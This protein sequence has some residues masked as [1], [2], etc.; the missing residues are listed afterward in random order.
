MTAVRF[1]PLAPE[2]AM[3]LL[4]SGEPVEHFGELRVGLAL[5]QRRIDRRAVD[6]A[7]EIGAIA[8]QGAR[9]GPSG[10]ASMI[11]FSAWVAAARLKVS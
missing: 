8:R 9:V 1:D 6:L 10:Q 4:D 7:L 2:L 11:T 5:G 3:G